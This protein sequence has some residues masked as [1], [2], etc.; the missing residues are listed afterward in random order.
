MW[1][2]FGF[3]IDQLKETFW[4]FLMGIFVTITLLIILYKNNLLG[5]T[6]T[7]NFI[8]K[9]SYYLFFPLYVG[10]LCWFASA[11]F[12]V[13]KDATEMARITMEKA[14]NS[15]FPEF[16][17]Y[18]LSLADSWLEG[19]VTSKEELIQNYLAKNDYQQG[20]LS[21]TALQWTLSNGIEY[22]KNQAVEKGTLEIGEEKINF[23]KLIADY[24]SG[25]DGLAK[26]PFSYL[27]GK[28]LG[29][30]HSYAKSFYWLYFFMGL[31]VVLILGLDIYF[32]QKNKKTETKTNFINPSTT[33][34]NNQK[35]LKNTVNKLEDSTKKL[36]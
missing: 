34:N 35:K 30:I 23:P 19:K 36:G 27:K 22:I 5:R 20:D 28:S 9:V 1:E 8:K 4:W 17:S 21:T 31:L 11:T 12:I 2:V 16:S 29:M 3:I 26:M 6:G 7:I 10:V 14:E 15:L 32:T 33:L 13:E 24:L 25:E 18:V